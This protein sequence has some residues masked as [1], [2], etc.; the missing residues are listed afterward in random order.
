MNLE[1]GTWVVVADGEK[2]LLL[3]NKGDQ[4]FLHLEVVDHA[5]S[6]NA[7]AHELSSDRSGR[8][9]DA[10]RDVSGQVESWGKSAMEETDWHRVAETRF[11]DELAGKLKDWAASGRF[12]H[13]VIVA[14]PRS[15]G[16]MRKAYD[17]ALRSVIV[18][19]IDKDL[20]NL[21]LDGIEASI[22]AYNAG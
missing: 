9:H 17:D 10:T 5:A 11:A 3:R 20:T 4:D 6:P 22:K 19:E 14:D 13:L 8:Q 1:N 7:P 15:L 18:A 2:Y 16:T 12:R 21:P